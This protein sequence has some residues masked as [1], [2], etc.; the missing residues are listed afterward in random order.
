MTGHD[1]SCDT[2]R[3]ASASWQSKKCQNYPQHPGV[4]PFNQR[5]AHRV[6]LTTDAA[7]VRA[8]RVYEKVGFVREG[9]R[10]EHW[11]ADGAWH[12]DHLYGILAREFNARYRPDGFAT[13]RL[14]RPT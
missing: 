4:G 12:D 13:R 2:T 10:R 1:V 6:G 14:R 9:T 7:N 5:A 8:Q 3:V 11:Y